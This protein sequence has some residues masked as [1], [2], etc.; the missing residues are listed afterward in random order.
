MSAPNLYPCTRGAIDV[1]YVDGVIHAGFGGEL[2]RVFVSVA[3]REHKVVHI[4]G[5]LHVVD[6]TALQMILNRAGFSSVRV[7]E[8]DVP[9]VAP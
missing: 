1:R 7:S 6:V 4:G 9:V 5:A 8:L 3:L 2:G